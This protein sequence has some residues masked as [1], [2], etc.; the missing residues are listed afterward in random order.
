MSRAYQ[1]WCGMISAAQ[2]REPKASPTTAGAASPFPSD[3]STALRT[4]SPTWAT[5]RRA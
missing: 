3:G 5:R 4:S 1:A 2:T